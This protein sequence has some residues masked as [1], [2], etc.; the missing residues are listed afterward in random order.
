[1]RIVAFKPG[2][3]GHIAH[4]TDGTLRLV[5]EAE[6]DSGFR[7]AAVDGTL[8]AESLQLIDTSPDVF[9]LSGWA[10]GANPNGRSIGA[11]YFG[12]NAVEHRRTSMFGVPLQHFSS[13]HERSHVLCAYALSPFPQGTPCYALTWEGYIGSFYEVDANVKVR[14]LGDIMLGP[15]VRY[16]AAYAI[17]DPTFALPPGGIRLG[18]AGK[19]MALAAYENNI[20]ATQQ[21]RA[22]LSKLL[23]SPLKP[24]DFCKDEFSEFDLFDSGTESTTSKRMARLIS[25][26]IFAYFKNKISPMVNERRPLLVSGGC[27]LNCEWNREWLDTGLFSDVFVP[28]CTNDTGAAIGTGADAQ[29]HVTGN[30]KLRWDVYCG[31]PFTDDIGADRHARLGSFVRVSNDLH[32]CQTSEQGSN[33]GLDFRQIRVGAKSTRQQIDSG[34]TFP[35]GHT[36]TSERHKAT[37]TVSADSAAVP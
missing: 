29:F 22:L 33:L 34:G 17:A 16:A 11:G 5:I 19:L 9:A 12:V 6:K 15:G 20:I 27:G 35:P 32:C 13:S 24:P 36:C 31:L 23:S 8:F 1:M 30:A 21:E 7:Y 4:I 25:D 26:T 3:D 18:D 14:K 2:H 28:P 10:T 37:R